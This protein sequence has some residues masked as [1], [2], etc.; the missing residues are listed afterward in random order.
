MNTKHQ[1]F[2]HENGIIGCELQVFKDFLVLQIGSGDSSIQIFADRR[3]QYGDL[4]HGV[5]EREVTTP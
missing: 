2:L 4:L 5:T 1:L 3:E